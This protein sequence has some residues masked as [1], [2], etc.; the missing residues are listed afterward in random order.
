MECWKT[1]RGFSNYQASD[2]G[3][4]RSKKGILKTSDDGNGYQKLM[5][6]GDDGK[7][8]CKKVHRLVAET[9]IPNN[10][11]NKDTVDH[12]ISGPEGK[13]NNSVSNLR[14][15]S[16]S[17]NI[18]KAYRDGVCNER[19]EKSKKMILCQDTWSG[20]EKAFYS[21]GE[22][23]KYYNIDRSRI[24]HN[25]SCDQETVGKRY[26]FEKIEGREKLLYDERDD[27]KQLSRI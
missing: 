22:A 27:Y 11:P 14:W 6:Y 23:A 16:R 18:K 19:I 4:I 9:F 5:I 15:I 21:V 10:D 24:S 7:R 2:Q 13:L 26:I 1:I 25:I 3:R 12:I 17:D 8:Y 20:E